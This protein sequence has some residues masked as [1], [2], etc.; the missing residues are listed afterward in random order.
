MAALEPGWNPSRKVRVI[1]GLPMPLAR[2]VAERAKGL[3]AT[4]STVIANA[5]ERA[6]EDGDRPDVGVVR[7]YRGNRVVRRSVILDASLNTEVKRV[8]KELGVKPS[9]VATAAVFEAL[10]STHERSAVFA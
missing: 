5:L 1:L 7:R 4:T 2:E 3:D 8:A 10:Q 9:E 6:L